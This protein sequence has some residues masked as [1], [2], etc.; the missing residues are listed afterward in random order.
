MNFYSFDYD[1]SFIFSIIQHNETNQNNI[2]TD[3]SQQR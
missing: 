2:I 3:E 1:T